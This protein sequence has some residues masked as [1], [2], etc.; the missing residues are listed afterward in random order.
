VA[1]I[2][3]AAIVNAN[4]QLDMHGGEGEVKTLQVREGGGRRCDTKPKI[5]AGKRRGKRGLK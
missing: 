1:E 5:K 2:S 4:C 3:P